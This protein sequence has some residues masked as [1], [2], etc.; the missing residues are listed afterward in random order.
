MRLS[1]SCAKCLYN[2]Q[3]QRVGDPVYLE[4]VK[5][6]IDNRGEKDSSSL[7]V[8]QFNE[9]QRKLYGHVKDFTDVKR[10]YNDLML[11]QLENFYDR[12]I[13]S[14][15]P[16]QTSLQLARVANYIDFGAMNSI[17]D[18][19]LM[20]L[21]DNISMSD[22]DQKVYDSLVSQL[23]EA[24]KFLLIT[25]NCG[26]IVLDTLF[27]EQ[28]HIKYPDIEISI[29]VRGA[30]AHNDAT[31]ADAIYVGLDKCGQ[32]VDNGY[33]IAGTVYDMLPEDSKQVFD[34]AD[35]IL[36]KGQG[37]YESLSGEGHHVFYALLCKCDLFISRFNV[38]LL[39]GILVEET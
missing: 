35:V 24:K 19:E 33:G 3:V 36:A 8:Y 6:I 9:L 12:I 28:L 34:E 2:K 15:D 18:E 39:T 27:L 25:D 11:E 23:K 4:Q 17:D 38:P 21:F 16:L 22:S 14:E 5:S 20:R 29:M 10:K 26:E 32:I 1:D 13:D 31:M 37:N 7:L 30:D